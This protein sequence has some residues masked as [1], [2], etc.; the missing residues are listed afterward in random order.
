MTILNYNTIGIKGKTAEEFLYRYITGERKFAVIRSV[1]DNKLDVMKLKVMTI[2]EKVIASGDAKI[3]TIIPV[4]DDSG[5]VDNYKL[6]KYKNLIL[7]YDNL[8]AHAIAKT[9]YI[10]AIK[11][12]YTYNYKKRVVS[13]LIFTIDKLSLT[14]NCDTR[15]VVVNVVRKIC[16]DK[17]F[18]NCNDIDKSNVAS[19]VK[20]YISA[21]AKK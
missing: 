2:Y 10:N 13:L 12:G 17:G 21:F 19:K 20:T 4:V 11:M 3:R 15:N 5:Y 7:R 18:E 6:M 8:P 16:N 9:V 1:N 14:L